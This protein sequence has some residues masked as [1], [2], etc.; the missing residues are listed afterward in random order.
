MRTV[1]SVECICLSDE[2]PLTIGSSYQS[3]IFYQLNSEIKDTQG[4]ICYVNHK[5]MYYD[6]ANSATKL[7]YG[8]EIRM[9]GL[10]IKFLDK[11]LLVCAKEG[12]LRIATRKRRR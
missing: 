10:W 2:K 1:K 6:D 5:W 12:D 4:I 9:A 3:D 11:Y 7:E 8:D